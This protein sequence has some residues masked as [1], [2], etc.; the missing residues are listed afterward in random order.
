MPGTTQNVVG[1]PLTLVSEPLNLGECIHWGPWRF[2]KHRLSLEIKYFCPSALGGCL[3]PALSLEEKPV[4]LEALWVVWRKERPL[5]GRKEER[6]CWKEQLGPE[7]RGQVRG[8]DDAG[9]NILIS[10]F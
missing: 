4:F 9:K 3:H 7:H 2:L 1:P 5:L 10:F 6:G 8:A